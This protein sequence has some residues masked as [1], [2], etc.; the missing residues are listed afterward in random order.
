M[1][2]EILR[3]LGYN[4]DWDGTCGTCSSRVVWHPKYGDITKMK[5][6]FCGAIDEPYN[7]CMIARN[8]RPKWCPRKR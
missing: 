8:S 4:T 3:E 6:I 5:R 7:K 1:D 2:Q